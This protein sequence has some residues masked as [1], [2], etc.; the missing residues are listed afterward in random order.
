MSHFTHIGL[1]VAAA[2][3]GAVFLAAVFLFEDEEGKIQSRLEAW[4]VGIEVT[5]VTALSST[6]RFIQAVA[7]LSGRAFDAVFGKKLFSVR[8]FAASVSLSLASV[9]LLVLLV[10]ASGA[11]N[12][13]QSVSLPGNM[14]FVGYFLLLG[15]L[16][17]VS[18][19]SELRIRS[20]SI[21]LLWIWYWLILAS[22][23]KPLLFVVALL[24][25]KSGRTFAMHTAE[26]L[27]TLL[28]FSFLCDATCI[29]ALRGVFRLVANGKGVLRLACLLILNLFLAGGF[30]IAPFILGL[31]VITHLPPLKLLGASVMFFGFA[32]NTIDVLI[33]LSFFA[34]A[35]VLVVHHALWPVISRLL[36]VLQRCGVVQ[37]RR[38][39]GVAGTVLMCYALG[40]G[41]WLLR[42]F[43][44]LV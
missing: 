31:L 7:A 42:L 30:F 14:E 2:L 25:E 43:K 22:I 28:I 40:L 12:A 32:L 39:F 3:V 18:E 41:D 15:L 27:V 4:W 37:R 17:A 29:A 36:Y 1:R 34:I 35:L 13:A 38:Q 20:V 11:S 44:V 5:R 16:P 9:G 21:P 26:V 23:V 24:D 10:L 8:A 19:G 6:A 33:C